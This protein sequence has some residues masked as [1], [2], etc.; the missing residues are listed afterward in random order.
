[1]TRVSPLLNIHAREGTTFANPDDHVCDG[2]AEPSPSE[3]RLH[4]IV[5]VGGGAAGLELVT[6]LGHRLGVRKRAEIALIDCARTH[7]WKPLLHEVAAGSLDAGAYEL[8]Y[9]AQA[10]WHHFRYLLG[11]MAALARGKREV[12]LAATFDDEGREVTPPR[13]VLYDT[14]VIA[15][16]SETND[17]GTPGVAQYAVQLETP[18]Q[19]ERFNRRLVNACLRAQTQLGPVRPGQLHVAIV[20]AGATGTELSAELHHTVR[21]VVAYGLDRIDPERDIRIVLIEAADRV[22]PGLPERMSKA[23]RRLLDGM[24]I[25]VRTGA[26]VAEITEEGLRLADGSFV[27]SELVV[28]AAGVRAPRVLRDLDGLEINRINQ[29]V[30]EPTLQ[31]TRDPDIFAIGD[32]AACPLSGES[33]TVPPRAQAAHQEAAHM[34]RQIERRLR[35]RALVPY[36][37]RDFGS[38]VSLGQWSTVGNLMGFLSGRSLLIEGLFAKLMYRSLSL[39]H[40][41]ALHGTASAAFGAIARALSRRSGPPVKL[42]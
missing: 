31:T 15:I 21:E 14:L 30:V 11:E 10:H 38:L 13:T 20:G 4:R 32:C 22:L 42:H 37:Y 34:L 17:F 39:M 12:H 1:V 40:E 18:A 3:Q 36:H 2:P 23:T 5:I 9:L 7:L 16:G 6:R 41:R 26:K 27:A 29:L 35:G 24:G 25:D 33:G 28:W 19:A 8:S